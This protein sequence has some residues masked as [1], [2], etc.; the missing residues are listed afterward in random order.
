MFESIIKTSR[1]AAVPIALFALSA[2]FFDQG[3]T[4]IALF[5]LVVA[6]I[7]VIFELIVFTKRGSSLA[8]YYAKSF[9]ASGGTDDY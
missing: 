3:N 7:F 9:R 5:H 4:G 2:Y 6:I 8:I 1:L